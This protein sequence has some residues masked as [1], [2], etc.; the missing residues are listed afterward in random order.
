[1]YNTQLGKSCEFAY[2]ELNYRQNDLEIITIFN[3]VFVSVTKYALGAPLKGSTA[4]TN[5]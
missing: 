4:K 1:M 5:F 3:N 2:T